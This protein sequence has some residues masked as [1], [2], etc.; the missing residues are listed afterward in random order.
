MSFITGPAQR[1]GQRPTG[2][3][4]GTSSTVSYLA[5]DLLKQSSG[6]NRASTKRKYTAT[7]GSDLATGLVIQGSTELTNEEAT[8][9]DGTTPPIAGDS[10]QNPD[11][12]I[13]YNGRGY[14]KF[15]SPVRMP[16]VNGSMSI[17]GNISATGSANF[18][19]A[20]SAGSGPELLDFD[21]T[22]E[23]G[24]VE[25]T[26][27]PGFPG[28]QPVSYTKL[29]D[30]F[31]FQVEYSWLDKNGAL[32]TDPLEIR[33]LPIMDGSRIEPQVEIP[34]YA[35]G[36]TAVELGSFFMLEFSNDDELSA[37]IYSVSSN[38]GNRIRI[39]AGDCAD[40]GTISFAV[41]LHSGLITS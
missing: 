27:N 37:F 40:T 22:V 21:M 8:D 6:P 12:P 36:V 18:G 29:G 11:F 26:R 38:T 10:M 9:P 15:V 28:S 16:S 13:S 31:I 35:L 19:G 3:R 39:T 34:V 14:M 33:G 2:N 25:F 7:I 24:G 20:F 41:V 30:L 1:R 17:L 23:A 32:D 4:H 5:E